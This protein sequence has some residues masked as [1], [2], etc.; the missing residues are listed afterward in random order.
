M[1]LEKAF[2]SWWKSGMPIVWCSTRLVPALCGLFVTSAGVGWQGTR[3]SGTGDI[4]KSLLFGPPT[5]QM[6]GRL[7]EYAPAM[8][9]INDRPPTARR[10]YKL[11]IFARYNFEI[12][13][14]AFNGDGTN[15]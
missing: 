4:P 7:S 2:S 9:L 3:G 15:L 1:T 13:G 12:E 11:G 14:A 6:T 5:R 10:N 8:A